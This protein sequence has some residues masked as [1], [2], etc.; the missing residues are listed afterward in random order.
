VIYWDTSALVKQ[1]LAEVGSEEVLAL[2]TQDLPHATSMITYSETFSALRRRVRERFLPAT[3][4]RTAIDLFKRDWSAFVRVQLDEEIIML[5]AKL[6]ERHP[7]RTL[8]SLH[9]ASV[10]QLQQLVG[11]PSLFVSSD[12]Q[13][14]QAATAE[15]LNVRHIAL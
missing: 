4:Y 8:D 5:S 10:L 6:I 1:Y 2:R 7:L 12:S 3:R 13:L 11:E 14:L 15:N 9:L